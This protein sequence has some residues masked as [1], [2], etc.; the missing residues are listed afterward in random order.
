[1]SSLRK[2]WLTSAAWLVTY[3]IVYL[4]RS[5][6]FGSSLGLW[7]P[8][9]TPVTIADTSKKRKDCAFKVLFWHKI[10]FE[11]RCVDMPVQNAPVTITVTLQST[12][13][14]LFE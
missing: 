6:F 1:M 10:S 14:V 11:T 12:N 5:E 4:D 9:N 7:V 3:L 2:H 8:Q 13:I